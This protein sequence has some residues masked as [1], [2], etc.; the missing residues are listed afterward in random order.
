MSPISFSVARHHHGYTDVLVAIHPVTVRTGV[1]CVNMGA[2]N[3]V[4]FF[5]LCKHCSSP[6]LKR[7]LFG[8]F[9]QAL[10]TLAEERGRSAPAHK[11]GLG[12]SRSSF[13]HILSS[14]R[15]KEAAIEIDPSLHDQLC[16]SL[17]TRY[18]I[19]GEIFR[20]LDGKK[21]NRLRLFYGIDKNIL[22]VPWEHKRSS[23]SALVSQPSPPLLEIS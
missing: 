12:S 17:E 8:N 9:P 21:S 6:F 18:F 2:K 7:F 23:S 13:N 1:L 5:C 4:T 22:H 11:S 14:F 10:G 3:L 19:G 20:I 16:A 15:R